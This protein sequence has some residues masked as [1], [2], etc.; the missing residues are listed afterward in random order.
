MAKLKIKSGS[1]ILEFWDDNDEI[2][3]AT[4]P[5]AVWNAAN[6]VDVYQY[7]KNPSH[8]NPGHQHGKPEW[9]DVP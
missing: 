3:I 4:F 7:K 2:F 5:N 6:K 9:I 1:V 8:G